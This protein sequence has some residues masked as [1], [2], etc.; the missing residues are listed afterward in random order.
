MTY[1]PNTRISQRESAQ[2]GCTEAQKGTEKVHRRAWTFIKESICRLKQL[3][4]LFVPPFPHSHQP[5]RGF[6]SQRPAAHR[7][8][9]DG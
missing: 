3:A 8:A 2:M 7:V 5:G 4:L 1:H 6:G 9:H